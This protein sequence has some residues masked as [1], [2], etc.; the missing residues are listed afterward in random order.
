LQPSKPPEFSPEV[1]FARCMAAKAVGS[2][3]VAYGWGRAA[4]G[5]G[6]VAGKIMSSL[7]STSTAAGQSVI[8]GSE[9]TAY[10]YCVKKCPGKVP[11]A[12]P[13]SMGGLNAP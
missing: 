12:C 9:L 6:V 4:Q 1:C 3:G 8:I 11:E 10:E 13:V 2:L 7:N 5:V